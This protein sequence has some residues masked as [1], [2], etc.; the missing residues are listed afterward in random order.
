VIV[1]RQGKGSFVAAGTDLGAEIRRRELDE[2]LA[3]AARVALLLGLGPE[4][5]ET[6]MREIHDQ[7]ATKEK[8]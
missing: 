1:T 4:E 8:T 7:L 6:R 2:H 5:L 3:A